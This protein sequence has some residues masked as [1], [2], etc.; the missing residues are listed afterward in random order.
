LEDS[1]VR[2]QYTDNDGI[3]QFVVLKETVTPVVI[4]MTVIP[5]SGT[6]E[7]PGQNINFSEWV[8]NANNQWVPQWT[9]GL[10]A[11]T[12]SGP[13]DQD[14]DAGAN[15]N[16]VVAD[17]GVTMRFLQ[18]V[19]NMV[20]GKSLL[21]PG[22][23]YQSG[24]GYADRNLR[25]PSFPLLDTLPDLAPFYGDEPPAPWPPFA[26]A[27]FYE[28]NDSPG[29][30]SPVVHKA[31][32]TVDQDATDAMNVKTQFIDVQFAFRLFMVVSY[33]RDDSIYAVASVDW[34]AN[35][36]A[37]F[38]AMAGRPVVVNKQ[39]VSSKPFKRSSDDPW[40][41]RPAAPEL[42]ESGDAGWR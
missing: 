8:Q 16:A 15:S 26:D 27:H 10:D 36:F 41:A 39:G 23:R 40:T 21:G 42:I 28:D 24:S 1:T 17:S 31:D 22:W 7:A 19:T 30:G 5:G 6:F 2:V 18:D 37:Q 3:V 13:N 9:E 14:P 33:P 11:I 25:Y 12:I 35:F 20:N 38:D 34:S 32:G 4:D 29:T